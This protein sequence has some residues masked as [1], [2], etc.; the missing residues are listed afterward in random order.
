M[1]T[2]FV[3]FFGL[4][5]YQRFS[6]FFIRILTVVL[7]VTFGLILYFANLDYTRFAPTV[8]EEIIS[9]F[10]N[11]ILELQ[12]RPRQQ[13][14]TTSITS[15]KTKVITPSSAIGKRENAIKR[16]ENVGVLKALKTQKNSTDLSGINNLD[17]GLWESEELTHIEKKFV[18]SGVFAKQR[19]MQRALLESNTADELMDISY[20]HSI[21]RKRA[22]FIANTKDIFKEPEQHFGYRDQAEIFR[23]IYSK[24]P[25]IEACYK[26][27]TRNYSLSSGFIKVEFQISP[28]GRVIGSSI[29]ILDSNLHSRMLE[30]CIKKN[31]R[32][33]RDFKKLDDSRGIAHV[34]HKFIFY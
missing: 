33:W 32:R 28:D 27:A 7:S 13:A 12:E 34:V 20:A 14:Q 22:I 26:K 19:N 1:K 30:Q 21:N 11:H 6:V 15:S 3:R 10:Q 8:H 24:Q 16:A 5:W 31:I 25:L 2:D 18:P 4:R 17:K 29:R 9:R 23:V